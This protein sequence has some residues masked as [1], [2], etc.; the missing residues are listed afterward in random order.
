MQ[1]LMDSAALENTIGHSGSS[2]LDEV[3][4]ITSH[5]KLLEGSQ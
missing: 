1:E 4:A 2:D 5:E 3:E